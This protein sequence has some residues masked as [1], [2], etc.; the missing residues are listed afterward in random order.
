MENFM[1]RIEINPKILLGKPIIHMTRIPVELIVKLVAQN[2]KEKDIL[3]EYPC[4]KKE[5]IRAA[6]LYAEKVIEEE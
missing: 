2:W 4:L 1:N 3:K 6:F 5:D